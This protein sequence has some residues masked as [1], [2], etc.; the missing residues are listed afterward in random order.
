MA[1]D[2]GGKVEPAT[3][4]DLLATPAP[5]RTVLVPLADGKKVSLTFRAVGRP[6]WQKL[7]GD[8]KP[9]D[10]DVDALGFRLRWHPESFE[11]AAVAASLADPVLSEAEVRELFASPAWSNGRLDALISAAIQV[12]EQSDVEALGKG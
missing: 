8:H 3:L 2:A 1:K 4:A 10:D 5:E 6:A 12:N 9:H 7:I 11:P